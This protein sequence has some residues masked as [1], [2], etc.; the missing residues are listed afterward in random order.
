MR[1]YPSF[2]RRFECRKACLN[3]FTQILQVIDIQVVGILEVVAWTYISKPSVNAALLTL[4]LLKVLHCSIASISTFH[5]RTKLGAFLQRPRFHTRVTEFRFSAV[6]LC[7]SETGT[8]VSGWLQDRRSP[9]AETVRG[10]ADRWRCRQAVWR[11]EHMRSQVG[12][13]W[14]M[15]AVGIT[16]SFMTN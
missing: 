6:R 4:F 15:A 2:E 7:R 13:C 14:L 16:L 11:W 12:S 1:V 3:V 8:R 9:Y 5:W 10:G